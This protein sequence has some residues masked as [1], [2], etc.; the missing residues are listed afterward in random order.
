MFQHLDQT[1]TRK[2]DVHVLR[3]V[4]I[5]V[6]TLDYSLER[7]LECSPDVHAG[8]ADTYTG[9]HTCTQACTHARHK[10]SR[11]HIA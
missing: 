4:P 10:V 8:F 5:N 2:T 3:N 7:F 6:R 11:H 1:V 9:M